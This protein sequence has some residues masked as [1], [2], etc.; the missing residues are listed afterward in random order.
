MKNIAL[1]FPGQGCQY[2]GMGQF[3]Y[4]SYEQARLVYEQAET[5]LGY[6]IRE[7]C[8]EGPLRKLAQIQ[9]TLP[10]I[11]VTSMAVYKA[12]ETDI[13]VAPVCAAGHSLGEYTALACSGALSLQDI[14]TLLAIRSDA[15]KKAVAEGRG[16]M[17]V[18]EET[19]IETIEGLCE[20]LTSGGMVISIACYN[21]KHQFVLV[22]KADA[23][24]AAGNA[25]KDYGARITPIRSSAPFHGILMQDACDELYDAIQ[26]MTI[27][28]PAYP[29]ISNRTGSYY[30]DVNEIRETLSKQIVSPVQWQKSMK[31]MEGQ[32][33]DTI[34]E[35][36]PQAIMSN[37]VKSNFTADVQIYSFGQKDDRE[38]LIQTRSRETEKTQTAPGATIITK[39]LAMAVCTKNNNTDEEAYAQG[40][41]TPYERI[42]EIQRQIE[43]DAA[44]PSREQMIESL[45]LLRT[46]MKT[47]EVPLEEQIERF[48]RVFT[49]SGREDMQAG[50]R[51]PGVGE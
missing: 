51:M 23:L 29:V 22:G 42:E 7:I 40:V 19:D 36:G 45:E 1:V 49:E 13:A 6:D 35:I 46:I 4:R 14:L 30:R 31:L 20:R 38:A 32:H 2:V 12:Y 18:A 47:K 17:L 9:Y 26:K 16:H 24:E 37:L 28:P 39:C 15:A 44:D 33:I 50:F 3:I 11:F 25:L 8:F 41:I 10:A 27:N 48:Q 5:Y 43:Q 21:A 34:V